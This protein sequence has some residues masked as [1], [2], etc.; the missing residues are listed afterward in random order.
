[1]L[2][3]PKKMYSIKLNHLSNQQS[4]EKMCAFSLTDKLG[5]EKPTL[6]KDLAV[7]ISLTTK[8]NYMC[9]VVFYPELLVS[10]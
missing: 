9:K 2:D 1:M 10:F 5:Q 6:W 8:S 4:M 3:V 7:N